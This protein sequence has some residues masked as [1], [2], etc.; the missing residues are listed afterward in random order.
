MSGSLRLENYLKRIRYTGA[1]APD[2]ATLNALHAAH[3]A[4]IPFEGLDPFC[5][6]PVKLDLESIQA[7]LVD[8]PRG[9]YCFEQNTLF[10]AV[11][12]AVG[13]EVTQLGARVRWMSPPDSPLGPRSHMLLKLD[14]DD[15][16][17]IADVGFGACVMDAPL[18]LEEEIEQRTAMG[19][20]RFD[21]RDGLF[22]LAVKQPNGWRE[23]YAFNLEPQLPSDAEQ[24]N[25]FTSTYP[26]APFTSNVIVERVDSSARYKLINRRYVKEARE[27]EVVEERAINDVDDCSKTFQEAFGIVLPSE[28]RQIFSRVPKD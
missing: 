16:T 2:L 10:K 24:A 12:E 14:L 20:Y 5:G 15:G 11:L 18:Q 6:R 8:S 1:L 4:A 13:F 17:Y 27:G 9:G 23:M 25:W 3:V 26:A 21:W 7:K 19:T 22:Y 28:I